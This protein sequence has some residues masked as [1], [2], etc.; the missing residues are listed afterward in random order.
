MMYA[1]GVSH[2]KLIKSDKFNSLEICTTNCEIYHN[3][4]SLVYEL[5]SYIDILYPCS[6]IRY[7]L[8]LKI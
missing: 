2:K 1:N 8:P 5:V 4:C 3:L 7:G 6:S